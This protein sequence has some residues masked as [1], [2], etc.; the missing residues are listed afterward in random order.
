MELTVLPMF[1]SLLLILSHYNYIIFTPY[2]HP[3]S[4]ILLKKNKT[5]GL[6]KINL[7]KVSDLKKYKA[8]H[9]AQI[10]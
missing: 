3:I 10:R 8:E 1:S 4:T 2:N 6:R 5:L 9:R 7:S